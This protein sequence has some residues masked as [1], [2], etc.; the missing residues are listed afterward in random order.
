[1]VE[2][3]GNSNVGAGPWCSVPRKEAA[4]T[5]DGDIPG[6][7]VEYEQGSL[8]TEGTIALFQRLIDNGMAWSLQGHYGR[9]A[10][11]LIEAGLCARKEGR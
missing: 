1:M 7:I 5:M 8:S 10:T 9:V 11:A 6:L 3:R 4:H 2:D